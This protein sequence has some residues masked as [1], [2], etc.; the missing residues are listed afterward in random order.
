MRL[1][2][3]VREL[4]A[5]T[6]TTIETIALYTDVDRNATFVREADT[7]YDLGPPAPRPGHGANREARPAGAGQPPPPRG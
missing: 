3:A 2:H 5:E 4:A 6:A 7:A 1:I